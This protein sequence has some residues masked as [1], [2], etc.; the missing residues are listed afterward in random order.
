MVIRRPA[1][2]PR[3][4]SLLAGDP[5]RAIR[6][7]DDNGLAA[8]HIA[9][10]GVVRGA[11]RT[12]R[13]QA[14]GGGLFAALR[15]GRDMISAAAAA[16]IAPALLADLLVTATSGGT[17][18]V[19]VSVP[20]PLGVAPRRYRLHSSAAARP[21][22]GVILTCVDVT[23]DLRTEQRLQHE[24][25]HDRLTGLWHRD[26]LLSEIASTLDSERD[27]RHVL[28]YVDLDG[29]KQVNDAHG[30]AVGDAVLIEAGRRLTDEVCHTDMVARLGG[31]EFALLCRDVATVLAAVQ[32]A[33]RVHQL[34]SM[35]YEV[36]GRQLIVSASVGCRVTGLRRHETAESLLGEATEAMYQAK[37]AGRDR[38][39]LYSPE[40]HERSVRRTDV[41]QA[42]GAALA[43]DE[44]HLV[45]QPQVSLETGAVLGVEALA[46]WTS[47]TL[48]EV[49]PEEFIPAAESSRMI[50][51][52]GE[53][54]LNEACRQMAEWEAGGAAPASITVN[55]S[56][57]QLVDP[58]FPDT[59]AEVL[60][61]HGVAA[62]R[63]CLEL[64]EAALMDAE[65]RVTATMRALHDVGVYLAIDDFGT[66]HSSLGHLRDL[67]VEV[68]KIDR[69]F[70]VGL[71]TD[72][73]AAGIVTAILSLAH[74]LGL[75]VVAEGVETEGQ[76]REL[77][78]RGCRVVQGMR[79]SLGVPGVLIPRLIEDGFRLSVDR[80]DRGHRRR[81][82][83]QLRAASADQLSGSAPLPRWATG[84]SCRLLV[85]E[86]MYQLGLPE[87]Q[88]R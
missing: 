39:A 66:G 40:Q 45:Y 85:A 73:D 67:P 51:R 30:H 1:D 15:D 4:H 14:A 77:V 50:L 9:D 69:S 32:R 57:L 64:T 7:F 33:H 42:L 46:R 59:V 62:R 10:E 25:M 49:H 55:V 58:G 43:A 26:V 56:P 18:Q 37:T 88:G 19:E 12:W 17:G 87:E 38:V 76:V 48:G 78:L 75:H 63:L 84:R 70:V 71:D 65:H 16:G 79:Y 21:P 6:T 44:L 81:S 86:L 5:A 31:D 36:A 53:W 52:L 34:L 13:R 72:S 24:S 28:V 54:V 35:P 8:I 61:T 23:I 60:D 2:P 74:V 41:E 68:L 83:A 11:N 22:G 20:G 29:L 47:P 3:T 82:G 27:Q 80:R